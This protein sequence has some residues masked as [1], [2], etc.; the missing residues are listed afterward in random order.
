V[1]INSEDAS[2][3]EP[4]IASA[5]VPVVLISY[6]DGAK[7]LANPTATL[8]LGR[9]VGIAGPISTPQSPVGM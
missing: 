7:L 4:S 3:F 6:T 8:S 2:P 9:D 5:N 1:I